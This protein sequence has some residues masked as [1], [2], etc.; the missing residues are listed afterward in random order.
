MLYT[1]VIL[2]RYTC[3]LIEERRA[4][5]SFNRYRTILMNYKHME[6]NEKVLNHSAKIKSQS[7]HLM[8][9]QKV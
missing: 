3:L 7:D 2:K 9:H 1:S 8:N 5:S 4:K 6:Y